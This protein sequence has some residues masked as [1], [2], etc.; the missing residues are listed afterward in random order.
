[1]IAG[2]SFASRDYPGL[3][4]IVRRFLQQTSVKVNR[5]VFAVAGP[6]VDGTALLTN[7][8]WSVSESRLREVFGLDSVHLVNDLVAMALAVP[9]LPPDAL[10]ILQ[11]GSPS[12][13]AP[14]AVIAPGT[15]LG[16]AFL[17][18]DGTRYVAHPSEGGHAD[19]AP[20]DQLQL[21]LL[22]WL[23]PRMTHVSYEVVC[24]GRGLPLLYRFL[25][26]RSPE[27]EPGGLAARIDQAPDPTPLIVE[28]GLSTAER[29]PTCAATL[30]L[31][32]SILAA[33]AG[34]A[35]LRVLAMGGVYL[36]GGLPRRLLPILERRDFIERFRRKGRMSAL[37]QRI[38][39]RVI[40]RP[41]VALLGAA[42]YAMLERTEAP[43]V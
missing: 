18:W 12:A 31:F 2:R 16:E 38:P 14:Q 20:A 3:E 9:H 27:P 7:L 40:V 37:L 11:Q 15:G 42:H 33:E 5:A 23:L 17:M 19:F 39:V 4:E 25:A 10:R 32:S 6:I 24:S 34:N 29:A 43:A 26:E 13:A 41:N 1:M 30:D 35:A 28:A 8:T 36:G 22:Q 21:E